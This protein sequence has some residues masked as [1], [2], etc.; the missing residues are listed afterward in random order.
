MTVDRKLSQTQGAIKK[1]WR[2]NNAFESFPTIQT[3]VDVAAASD[4]SVAAAVTL[5]AAATTTISGGSV[6]DPN[7]YRALRIKGNQAGVAGNVVI[8]GYDRGGKVVTDTIA[9]NGASAVDGVIPML[10]LASITFPAL[11]GAGDTISVGVSEKLGLYRPIESTADVVLAERK[12]TAA[13]E[14]TVESSTGTVNAT[15]GTIVP[16]GGI[17][18]DDSFKFSLETKIF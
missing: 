11:V 10:T 9:A 8:T 5:A 4:T 2:V 13:D 18:A 15:Y 16:S 12:A 14:F 7:E 17:V 6:T 3:M 1:N